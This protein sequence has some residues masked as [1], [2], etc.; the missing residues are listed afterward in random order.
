MRRV[1][2]TTGGA[3]AGDDERVRSMS[4]L[5]LASSEW[6]APRSDA[7]LPGNKKKK[8]SKNRSYGEPRGTH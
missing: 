5:D 4:L 3:W 8:I 7:A 2:V 1:F 6:V